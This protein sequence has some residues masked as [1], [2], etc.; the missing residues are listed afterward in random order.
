MNE[1][2]ATVDAVYELMHQPIMAEISEGY[3]QRHGADVP[4][5]GR[6]GVR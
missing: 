5:S 2:G 1:I 4:R 6:Q 3:S